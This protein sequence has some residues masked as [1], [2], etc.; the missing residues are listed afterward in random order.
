MREG[1]ELDIDAA[2]A[3]VREQL[4]KEKNVSPA[5]KSAIELC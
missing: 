1:K 5:F 3:N 4:N 2:I